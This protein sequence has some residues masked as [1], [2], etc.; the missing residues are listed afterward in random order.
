MGRAEADLSHVPAVMR[1]LP[2]LEELRGNRAVV[3][4]GRIDEEASQV[5]YEHLRRMG[6]TP[7]LDL[8]LATQGGI[9]T[10]A[11]RMALLLHEYTDH[12]AVL[13][14]HRAWS[15]GTLLCLAA[16]ELVLGPLA[17]LGPLDPRIGSLGG[18]ESG[19]PASVSAEDVRA[20]RRLAEEWFGV[21]REEDRLQVLALLAQRVFPASLGS[22]YRADRLVRRMAAEL[23]EYQ[24]PDTDP[25][26]REEIVD[27]LVGGYDAHEYA[28][29]RGQVRQLGLRVTYPSPEEEALLW[30]VVLGCRD[31]AA[32]TDG[33][34]ALS[35]VV[36]SDY[37]AHRARRSGCGPGDD[38][39]VG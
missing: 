17:E 19:Q 31:E 15:A 34:Q 26:V 30:D 22:F 1:E 3:F 23:L 16:H 9:A 10:A 38:R 39:E 36:S 11:R 27:H 21:D 6:R 4:Y 12:L 20:F 13:V 35:I 24:L 5:V 37:P 7:R 29:T 25:A 2:E 28:I 18:P 32:R 8:V 14:A 33:G